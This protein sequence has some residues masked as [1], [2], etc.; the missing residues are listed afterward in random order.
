MLKVRLS[1]C[2][3]SHDEL[4]GVLNNDSACPYGSELDGCFYDPEA[5]HWQDKRLLMLR[6]GIDLDTPKGD[7]SLEE[8]AKSQKAMAECYLLGEIESKDY[9]LFCLALGFTANK[10]STQKIQAMLN[11]AQMIDLIEKI[12]QVDIDRVLGK[13]E[14]DA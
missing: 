1:A 3:N 12:K 2:P 10:M 14:T 6:T 9:R 7:M 8:V 4:C 13:K 5:P 11:S